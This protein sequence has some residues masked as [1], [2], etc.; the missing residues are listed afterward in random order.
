MHII[1]ASSSPRRSEL[2]R[3]AGLE[4]TVVPAHITEEPLPGEPPQQT[5]ERLAL[6]KAKAIFQRHPD[7]AV[8]G[9]DTIV[10][11]EGDQL[12][13]PADEADA[14]RMLRRLSGRAHEVITGVA[15]VW[16]GGRDIRSERTEVRFGALADDEIAEYIASGEPMDKAGAYGIQGRASRWI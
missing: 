2:L 4:F 7:A 16:P 8:L 3:H 13:K 5:A 6:E 9:A 11:V 12:A 14:A 10:V 15:L 1:L